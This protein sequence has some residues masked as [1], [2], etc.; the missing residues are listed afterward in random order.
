MIQICRYG[1]LRN[2]FKKLCPTLIG[3]TL[4]SL[5]TI[6]IAILLKH[7]TIFLP[8]TPKASHTSLENSGQLTC[9]PQKFYGS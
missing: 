4:A 1:K 2:L 7:C 5:G 3:I 8:V 6:S 9:E